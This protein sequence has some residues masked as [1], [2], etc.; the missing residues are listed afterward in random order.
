MP[1]FPGCNHNRHRRVFLSSPLSPTTSLQKFQ[2]P[3]VP[4][5]SFDLTLCMHYLPP[6]LCSSKGSSGGFGPDGFPSSDAAE[7]LV[8]VPGR[9]SRSTSVVNIR[10]PNSSSHQQSCHPLLLTLTGSRRGCFLSLLVLYR[11]PLGQRLGLGPS[12]TGQGLV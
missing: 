1:H 4:A 12:G 11:S 9:G 2:F 7:C 8:K 5:S 10:L 3:G 6:L